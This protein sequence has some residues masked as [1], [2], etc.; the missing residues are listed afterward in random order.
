MFQQPISATQLAQF[1]RV[2]GAFAGFG[3]LVDV[4][5]VHPFVQGHRMDT[6]IGG[7]LLDR[8][9]G[10]AVASDADHVVTELLG[11]KAWAQGHPSSL[12]TTGKPTQMSPI[13]AADPDSY[14]IASVPR[15]EFVD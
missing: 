14:A 12:P 5:L 3:A 6:E 7:D 1:S 11:G 9:T 13:H 15:L 2:A 4:G 8:H 10:F